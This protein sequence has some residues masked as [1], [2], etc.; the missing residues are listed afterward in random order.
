MVQDKKK[1]NSD[2]VDK[3]RAQAKDSLKK[4]IFPES[5]DERIL[6]AVDFLNKEKIVKPILI[7]GRPDIDAV[8]KKAGI[9]LEGIEIRD[10]LFDDNTEHFTEQFHELRKKKGMTAE[11][12][13]EAMKD[14][15][16]F[17]TMMV[18]NDMADGIVSGAEHTTADTLRP[19]LQ[20]IKTTDDVKT[21]SSF[22]FM[23]LDEKIYLFSDCGFVIDPSAEEL[24]D[25][26]LTTAGSAR[27]FNL[28]PKVAMLSFSTKG[29]AKHERVD[30]VIKATELVKKRQTKDFDFPVDGEM[31][32]DA[33]I[34][35]KV[36]KKKCPSCE[37]HGDANVLIFP[38]LDAGNIGYKLVQRLAGA[39]A[40]GPIVQGLKKPV[41]DLSRGCGV[42]D[43]IN[44]A[45]ITAVQAKR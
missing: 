45:A 32:L 14:N 7:G 10:P 31:Q 39:E 37:L 36:C 28:E 40:I 3:I 34:V 6:Q 18:F 41:N 8:A 4:I 27:F 17:A 9:D 11:K 26:A 30:K 25:I 12:A 19:A 35:P 21:A 29:S 38:N 1:N 22:F 33:A 15:V 16:Y 2:F 5:T 44:V 23:L 20:I 42:E 24:A 13:A 43:I